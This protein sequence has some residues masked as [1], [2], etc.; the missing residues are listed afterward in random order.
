MNRLYNVSI[1]AHTRM[2]SGQPG[3]RRLHISFNRTRV[4]V[5]AK[6]AVHGGHGLTV[7][8]LVAQ[9][10]QGVFDLAGQLR[11]Q[12]RAVH[13]VVGVGG[14]VGR[15]VRTDATRALC[16]PGGKFKTGDSRKMALGFS[17]MPKSA[18]LKIFIDNQ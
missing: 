6:V 12:V 15:P 14:G 9:V 17:L 18:K 4:Q 5:L 13:G 8:Q 16:A 3:R 10:D 2:G 11:R 1:H 7:G